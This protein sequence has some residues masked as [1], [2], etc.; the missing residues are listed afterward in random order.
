M[1]VKVIVPSA[2][3]DQE[4][5]D[6]YHL[7]V[8]MLGASPQAPVEVSYSFER[9]DEAANR[10]Q[11]S[12][13]IAPEDYDENAYQAIALSIPRIAATQEYAYRIALCLFTGARAAAH[14]L[15]KREEP[16]FLHVVRGSSL[17]A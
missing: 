5:E 2:W 16:G 3:A 12:F 10:S 8:R 11:I 1:K 4:L 14:A 6:F 9:N 7:A 13:V 15:A 17:V